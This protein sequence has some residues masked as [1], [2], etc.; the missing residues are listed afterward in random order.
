[1]IESIETTESETTGSNFAEI[2]ENSHATVFDIAGIRAH[3]SF[4]AEPYIERFDPW[5]EVA[6]VPD[7]NPD[8]DFEH[9]ENR[10][11]GR[12]LQVDGRPRGH[13]GGSKQKHKHVQVR[14]LSPQER[15][16]KRCALIA[17]TAP[18]AYLNETPNQRAERQLN[19]ARK[20]IERQERSSTGR[21]R[22]GT[23]AMKQY[24]LRLEPSTVAHIQAATGLSVRD[25]VEQQAALLP[26]AVAA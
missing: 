20:K 17:C 3:G 18:E 13:S 14:P 10:I 6:K 9:D 1:L 16:D 22:R 5:Q 4:V 8:Y 7:S 26:E 15:M 19:E 2:D 21:P 12:T 23:E 11:S 24:G 25:F